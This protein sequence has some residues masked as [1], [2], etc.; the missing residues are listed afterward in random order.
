MFFKNVLD[1]KHIEKILQAFEICHYQT[2]K[3]QMIDQ[4]KLNKFHLLL[5][6]HFKRTKSKIEGH[7]KV[8]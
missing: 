7:S 6:Q 4:R 8:L 1:L 2:C 3:Q 5:L